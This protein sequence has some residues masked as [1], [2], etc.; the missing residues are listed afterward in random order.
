[1]CVSPIYSILNI[2]THVLLADGPEVLMRFMSF[3]CLHSARDESV[4]GWKI[5]QEIRRLL[6]MDWEVNICYSY[7][8]AND[9]ADALANLGCN[10]DPGLRVYEQCPPSVSSLMLADVMGIIRRLLAMDWEGYVCM[11]NVRLV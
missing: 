4:V 8:K 11:S 6:A 7:R 3:Q 5:I 1:M 9:C 10:H 2:F